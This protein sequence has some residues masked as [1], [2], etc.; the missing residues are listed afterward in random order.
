[1]KRYVNEGGVLRGI[2]TFSRDANSVK[3]FYPLENG[4]TL[5]ERTCS[6]G[7]YILSVRVGLFFF[8]FF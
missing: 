3:I 4:S 6:H 2:D 7:E 8:F 5:I 1:M